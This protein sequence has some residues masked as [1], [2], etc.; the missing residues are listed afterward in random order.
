MVVIFE[1][2]QTFH[3]RLCFNT[4][5]VKREGGGSRGWQGGQTNGI[6]FHDSTQQRASVLTRSKALLFLVVSW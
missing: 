5:G 3:K 4:K 6:E 2:M 1:G